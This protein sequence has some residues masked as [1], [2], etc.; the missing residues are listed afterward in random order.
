MAYRVGAS[1]VATAL[2]AQDL[3]LSTAHPVP[4]ETGYA[5]FVR[6]AEAWTLNQ[7]RTEPSGSVLVSSVAV[8]PHFPECSIAGELADGAT[9]GWLVVMPALCAWALLYLRKVL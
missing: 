1:C 2:D 3:T 6:G 5:A 7:Y 8:P 9:L 4:T